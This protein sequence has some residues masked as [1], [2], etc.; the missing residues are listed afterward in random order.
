MP[1]RLTTMYH[2]CGVKCPLVVMYCSE[3]SPTFWATSCE[4]ALSSCVSRALANSSHVWYAIEL[5]GLFRLA[6]ISLQP[7][8]PKVSET[9]HE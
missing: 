1:T 7:R 4:V 3:N 6:D 5:H 2:Q 8:K 9:V